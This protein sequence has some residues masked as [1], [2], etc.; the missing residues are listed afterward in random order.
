MWLG[1][2]R[3]SYRGRTGSGKLHFGPAS[4]LSFAA[5]LVRELIPG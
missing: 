5:R 1:F 2:C 4:A 3:D